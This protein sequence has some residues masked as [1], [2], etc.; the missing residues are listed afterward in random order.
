MQT[1]VELDSMLERPKSTILTTR[2]SALGPSSR[3]ERRLRRRLAKRRNEIARLRDEI[4]RL[5][6]TLSAH[7]S[8]KK[9]SK[10]QV[11]IGAMRCGTTYLFNLLSQ[12]PHVEPSIRKEV[13]YFDTNYDQGLDWYRSHFPT[14]A[15]NNKQRTITGE[16]TPYYLAH[17]QA[18]KRVA[19][20]LPKAKLIVLLRNPVDRTYSH[21]NFRAAR[22][23]E[24]MTFEEAVEA[25][26]NRMR[27]DSAHRRNSFLTR[28]IYVDQLRQWTEFF[29]GKQMLVLKSENFFAHV[30]ETLKQT[31]R[32]L[33]LPEW[34][35]DL[36]SMSGRNSGSYKEPMNLETRRWLEEFFEPHNQRLYEYLGTDFGW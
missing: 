11:I 23:G 24:K 18:A 16:A 27:Y 32:F 34:E 15:Q 5:K 36:S 28:S 19:E 4:A 35:P 13:H 30:P 10:V 31:L 1:S 3:R 20:V 22:I 14:L 17:P 21:H 2:D 8:I 6:S 29:D 9:D 26:W 7:P 12:H 25:D 33:N